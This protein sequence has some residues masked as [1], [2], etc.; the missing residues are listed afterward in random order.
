MIRIGDAVL[1]KGG[2]RVSNSIEIPPSF[3]RYF[4]SLNFYVEYENDVSQVPL[5]I[6]NIPALSSII[7]FAW[8]IGCDVHIGEADR[9]YLRGLETVRRI[10]SRQLGFEVLDLRSSVEVDKEV[11]NSFEAKGKGLLFSGGVDS[12]ASYIANI[13][14][15]P[16]LITIWGMDVPTDW[17][18]FWDKVTEKYA[19]MGP[20]KIK[21]NSDEIYRLNDLWSLGA[22]RASTKGLIEGYRPTYS[23]FVNMLGICAPLTVLEGI[24][25]LMFSSTYPS[26]QYGDPNY[27]WAWQRASFIL[28]QHFRWGGIRCREVE[29]EYTT[30][31]KVKYFIKPYFKEQGALTLRSCGHRRLLE[32]HKLERLNCSECDKCG[33]VIGMLIVN[34]V[35]PNTCGF[36]ATAETYEM[37]K[38]SIVEKLWNPTYLKYHWQEIQDF[39]PETII[40]DFSGSKRFLEWLRDYPL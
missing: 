25:E 1:D 13:H 3:S 16:K 23:F 40:E 37:I 9:E 19:W 34:G 17:T 4:S 24:G 30:N 21:T 29:H 22:K 18:D 39:I 10:L 6:L 7:H 5:S 2:R 26:R 35:D 27:P 36:Q 32:K 38:A 28:A 11:E 12:T 14:A 31:E 33:R 15:Y 8:A 20:L